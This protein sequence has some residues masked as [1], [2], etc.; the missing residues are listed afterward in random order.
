MPSKPDFDPA[1][2]LPCDRI[3]QMSRGT[4]GL[5]IDKALFPIDDL[6]DVAERENPKR[7][8]LFVSKVLGRHIPVGAGLHRQILQMLAG[9]A[10]QYL[11]DDGDVLVMG[12]A[13]TAVGLGAGIHDEL[14]AMFPARSMAYLASTRHPQDRDIWFSFSE[15][16][17][18]ATSHHV[19]VPQSGQV[20][21]IAETASTLVIVDDEATTGN[22]FSNLV[23][24]LRIAG[25]HFDRIILVTLTDWSQGAAAQ[26]VAEQALLD[27]QAVYNATLVSGRFSWEPAGIQQQ[28]LPAGIAVTQGAGIAPSC[29]A[30]RAGIIGATS[31]D[32]ALQAVDRA[33]P[34]QGSQ[35]V[36]GTGELVWQAFRLSEDLAARGMQSAFLATTRS[37]VL[38]NGPILHKAV[39]A[40][41]Y[42]IGVQMYL[43]NVD[44]ARW[45]RIIV[46]V[47]GDCP[48]F[49]D[50]RLAAYL[51]NFIAVT[52]EGDVTVYTDGVAQ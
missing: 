1:A 20:R 11:P 23:S 5:M 44:P 48:G 45:D 9:Q 41:H 40:D 17:S 14:R 13:E 52:I 16:H 49:I 25:R 29:G 36:I 33:G 51:G 31:V 37:P 50:D 8:F 19:L 28:A 6:L 34:T 12:Y 35:L 46:L 47:E 30:W 38:Q 7:A 42:G 22:T 26:A 3:Y 15:D 21:D 43:H 10:A 39:F 27:P 2:T 18:H 24:A 32:D 4:M